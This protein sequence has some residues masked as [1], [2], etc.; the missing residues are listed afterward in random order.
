MTFYSNY[1]VFL[2]YKESDNFTKNKIQL[3]SSCFSRST[4][5]VTSFALSTS[6]ITETYSIILH[7]MP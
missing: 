7:E 3:L 4:L 5:H 1:K 2:N 6:P